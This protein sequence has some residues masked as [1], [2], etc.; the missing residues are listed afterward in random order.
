MAE[1]RRSPRLRTI[2]GGSIMFGGATTVDCIIRNMSE[3]GAALEVE[4]PT[5]MP[6]VFTLLI[7]PEIIK[8]SCQVVWRTER[9]IGVR[10]RP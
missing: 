4:N 10:F 5:V 3:T 9:R 6:D 7:R 1:K 8:R 2:K